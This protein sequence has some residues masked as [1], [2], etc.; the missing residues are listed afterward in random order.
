MYKQRSALL[1]SGPEENVKG[2]SFIT[3]MC[4]KPAF[5]LNNT[6][7][8]VPHRILLNQLLNDVWY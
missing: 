6:D 1:K 8:T 2:N 5:T 4:S 7:P 3:V